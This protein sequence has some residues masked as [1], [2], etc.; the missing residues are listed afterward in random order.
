MGCVHFETHTT[1]VQN[2]YGSHGNEKYSIVFRDLELEFSVISW[3]LLFVEL[4]SFTK[5]WLAYSTPR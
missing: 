3:T 1:P 2:K 5:I 4:P